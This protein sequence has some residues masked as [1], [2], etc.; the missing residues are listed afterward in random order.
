[1][2]IS[3]VIESCRTTRAPAHFHSG[4][5]VLALVV[6]ELLNIGGVGDLIFG[7]T[8]LFHAL[9]QH[10]K[11]L[12]KERDDFDKRD[13]RRAKPQRYCATNVGQKI[14]ELHGIK[15]L[16]KGLSDV[17]EVLFKSMSFNKTPA[18]LST[19]VIIVYAHESTQVSR[20][21]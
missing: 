19:F 13:N 9:A 11:Q 17:V 10:E 2:I 5:L 16:N 14:G 12:S 8:E 6:V 1:M 3:Q 20:S 21:F 18:H 15:T 4:G 7:A